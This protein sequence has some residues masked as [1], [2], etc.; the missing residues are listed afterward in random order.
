MLFKDLKFTVITVCLNAEDSIQKTIESVLMQKYSPYEYL[1]IDGES[2][3]NTVSIAK[4]YE[5]DFADKGIRYFVISEKDTGIYNAMNK[6]I[7]KATGDFISFLNAGDTYLEDSLIIIRDFYA[8]S[9]FDMTYG[10][11]NYIN[12]DGSMI[13]K[14]SKYDRHWVTSRHWNHPSMFLRSEIYQKYGF[15]E[16]YRIYA[17]FHLY[18]KLRKIKDLRIRVIPKIITNFSA[19]G[20]ST[21]SSVRCA[22]ERGRE[23]YEIYKNNGYS[24]LYFFES[25]LWEIVKLLYFG[26][27][28]IKL[29]LQHKNESFSD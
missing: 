23:K 9:P 27:K 2:K 5:G 1:I 11:L 13:V 20:I 21:K 7:R 15:D 8:E 14:M 12:P 3:D 16:Q 25:Y 6:G 24:R 29:K 19:N 10:G 22:A 28:S 4:E 18:T 17:D 26:T